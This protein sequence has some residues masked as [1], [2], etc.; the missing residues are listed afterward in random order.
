MGLLVGGAVSARPDWLADL[1]LDVWMLPEFGRQ[2]ERER[3]RSAELDVD[4]KHALERL[5]AEKRLVA[6]V[7][8]GRRTLWE[9][10][11]RLR[12]LPHAAPSFWEMFRLDVEGTSDDEKMCRHVIGWVRASAPPGPDQARAAAV[13]DRLQAELDER[14]CL[15]G[16]VCLP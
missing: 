12:D 14:L 2:L 1:G 13:A 16:T 10:A 11:A 5:E 6:E 3:L 7:I 4:L 9:A 15:Y 8:D